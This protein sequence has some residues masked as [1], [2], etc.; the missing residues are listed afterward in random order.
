MP[1]CQLWDT[2]IGKENEHGKATWKSDVEKQH[3]K[4]ISNLRVPTKEVCM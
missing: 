3:S 4:I 1:F 2:D